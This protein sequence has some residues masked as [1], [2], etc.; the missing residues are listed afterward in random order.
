[1][2]DRSPSEHI[3]G[4][5]HPGEESSSVALLKVS[6]LF[7]LWK[8]FFQFFEEFFLIRYEVEGQG[9]RI[10][11][12]CK[13][14]VVICDFELYKINWIECCMEENLKMFTMFGTAEVLTQVRSWVIVFWTSV[15]SD[16][17]LLP[18]ESPPDG[19]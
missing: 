7:S 4:S 5:L 18:E 16:L 6:S 19:L 15:Q 1:M 13:A 2:D 9:C 8:V 14:Q 17:F 11:T 12:D 10:C 3:Y